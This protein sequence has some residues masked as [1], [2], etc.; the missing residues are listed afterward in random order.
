[1][2]KA[3]VV[4]LILAILLS[5]LMGCLFVKPATANPES[6]I[7]NLSMPVEYINYT[8]TSIKGTLWVKIDGYYPIYLLKQMDCSFTGDLPMVYP[9]PPQTSNIKVSL[10][11]KEVSWS[12][13][14]QIY[15]DALH[16][17]ALGDW[18]MIYCNLENILD[19]FELKIHYEHPIMQTND[20]YQFLYDLNISPY[21]SALDLNSK[22]Y[23]TL[24]FYENV[25]SMQIFTSP[26]DG[27]LNRLNFTVEGQNKT[28]Q[29]DFTVTSEYSKPLPGD[30][31]VRFNH[32]S[33]E[34]AFNW[35]PYTIIPLSLASIAVI[36]FI[37]KRKKQLWN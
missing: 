7:P 34:E 19:Y 25:S 1:M 10:D 3:T 31:I 4:M 29:V 13:Y 32:D 20:A 37:K 16:H 12:N 35:I 15:P 23:F 11:N 14:T 6:S 9:M 18:W 5:T 28:P 33:S 17:T 22:A 8:I 27:S 2:K 26:S 30:I 24:T 36:A 21:L